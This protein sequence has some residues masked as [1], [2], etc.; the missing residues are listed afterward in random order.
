MVRIIV[1]MSIGKIMRRILDVAD[2]DIGI[3]V[4]RASTI[5]AV[6]AVR[7][8]GK[9]GIDTV[10]ASVSAKASGWP[11]G[12]DACDGAVASADAIACYIATARQ[13]A[14]PAGVFAV[15]GA[16]RIA[17]AAHAET[18]T[19]LVAAK[20]SPTV[21]T[22]G[23]LH[24]GRALALCKSDAAAICSTVTSTIAHADDGILL[25]DSVPTAGV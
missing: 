1:G 24:A 18:I 25:T 14:L 13:G 19:A 11:P 15:G 5:C 23:T 10:S 22:A 20:I 3:P 9:T 2:D 8:T 6:P 12:T 7:I 4:T 17:K 16:E 21:H